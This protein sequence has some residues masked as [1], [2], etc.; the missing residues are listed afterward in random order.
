MPAWWEGL[1]KNSCPYWDVGEGDKRQASNRKE[2]W[3]GK[4]L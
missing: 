4:T 3:G 1:G 2:G